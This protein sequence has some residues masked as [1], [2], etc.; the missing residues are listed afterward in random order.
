MSQSSQNKPTPF[1]FDKKN[2]SLIDEVLARYPE[3]RKQSALLPLLWLAQRQNGGWL[4]VSAL[5]EVARILNV[6]FLRVYEVATF[7]TM[8]RLKP[9]GKHFIQICRTTSC[10]LRGCESLKETCFRLLKVDAGDVTQ[11]GLFSFEEVECLGACANGPVVQINDQY[12][13]DL[14]PKALQNLLE[15]L[16]RNLPVTS[17]SQRN[18]KAS[19]AEL[20]QT[21]GEKT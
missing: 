6:P 16:S 17:G 10:W 3:D 2:Q 21:I 13:E 1:T 20:P 5:E 19:K 18:R 14:T 9:V 11:D 15:N 12:F 7:Y 4:S 8:F